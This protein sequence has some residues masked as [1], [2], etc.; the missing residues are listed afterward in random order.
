MACQVSAGWGATVSLALPPF[1]AHST[2]PVLQRRQTKAPASNQLWRAGPRLH[3]WRLTR[4]RPISGSYVV[5]LLHLFCWQPALAA[6]AG[7]GSQEAA[8][9]LYE[10]S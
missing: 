10:W 6:H 4:G 7:F 1:L 5:S 2:R 8:Y 3:T 9:R